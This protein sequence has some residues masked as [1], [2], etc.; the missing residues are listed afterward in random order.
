M[1]DDIKISGNMSTNWRFQLLLTLLTFPI[2]STTSVF[3]Q[4]VLHQNASYWA[5]L[6]QPKAPA[7]P[8]KLDLQLKTGSTKA[9]HFLFVF[10]NYQNLNGHMSQV[11]HINIIINLFSEKKIEYGAMV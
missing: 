10:Q 1:K 2:W 4:G 5:G 9:T 6:L 11:Q 3:F 7:A 8:V